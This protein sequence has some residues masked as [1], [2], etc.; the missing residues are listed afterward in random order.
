MF[1]ESVRDRR[2][3]ATRSEIVDAA[4]AM[5]REAG[6][7]ALSMRELGARVGM[8]AA[9]LYRY[10][11]SKADIYDALFADG[12]LQL[13]AHL[14]VDPPDPDD[15]PAAVFRRSSHRMM[16][17]CVSDPARYALL[18][19]RPVPEF[20]PSDASMELARQS[21]RHLLSDLAGIGVTDQA[22]IDLWAA[23]HLGLTG[24]QV[25]ND[26]GGHRWVSLVDEA[27]DMF[28]AHVGAQPERRGTG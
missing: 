8:T 5:L 23:V 3:T 14:Q 9:A 17:F 16:S 20:R 10:F 11:P 21:Y 13:Q 18:F 7:G 26:P 6:P 25:A 27:V 24:Q 1:T 2:R 15:D 28:L 19:Q 22:T 4:W 12:H